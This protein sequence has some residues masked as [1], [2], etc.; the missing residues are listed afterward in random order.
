MRLY[1]S[2]VSDRIN[3]SIHASVKDATFWAPVLVAHLFCFNPRICKRCDI[4]PKSL[5]PCATFVSI[6]ASVKDATLPY[7]LKKRLRICFNPRICKRCDCP[8]LHRLASWIGFN[9]RICKR[10]DIQLNIIRPSLLF[11]STHL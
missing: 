3:V 6:H 5:M 11:Q 4:K 8:F 2:S 7:G 10:C 9:P 1:L